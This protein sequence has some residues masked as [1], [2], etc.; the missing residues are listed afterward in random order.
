[1]ESD[2]KEL[3]N[4]IM[5]WFYFN[6]YGT[7]LQA[8]AL[9]EF[10]NIHGNKTEV[11]NYIPQYDSKNEKYLEENFISKLKRCFI[12]F[13]IQIRYGKKI[14]NKELKFKKFRD[15]NIRFTKKSY[16]KNDL[17]NLNKKYDNFIVGS[18]QVWNPNFKDMS[19]YLDFTEKDKNR[20]S[21]APSFAVKQLE[22][23]DKINI[24]SNLERFDYI[25]VREEDGKNIVKNLINKDVDIVLDPTFLLKKEDWLKFVN[26]KSDE[27][28]ILCYFL[29]EQKYYWE[30][31]QKL[32]EQTG[33]SLKVIP[34]TRKA[35]LKEKNLIIDVGPIEFLEL[36]NN[37][38]IICTDSFHGA[39]F[40]IIF[41][42]NFSVLKKFKDTDKKSQNSRIYNL[43]KLFKLEN[44][45]ISS[46]F[47]EVQYLVSDYNNVNNIL[48]AERKK[49][50]D[51]IINAV[52]RK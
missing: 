41:E 28:Y 29:G 27:K 3:N 44:H 43:L 38:E 7:N 12:N 33:Y 15:E 8:Y 25:S 19:Y 30:Y 50:V 36:I 11:V 14:R 39:V 23:E 18:D 52:N 34:V 6:N 17:K 48:E 16:S 1:M 49:S 37:A 4:C 42:K 24:K 51:Y 31:A 47:K 2:N 20:I 40:S 22:D 9:Q 10:L 46:D 5:T 13:L 35:F 45:L 32:K 21:Y 26:K